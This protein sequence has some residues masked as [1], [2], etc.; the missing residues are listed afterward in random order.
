[1]KSPLAILLYFTLS[2]FSCDV[3]KEVTKEENCA[4]KF[5]IN[6]SSILEGDAARITGRVF[7]LES[8]EVI[9]GATVTLKKEGVLVGSTTDM[10]GKFEIKNVEAGIYELVARSIG[11]NDYTK[12]IEIKN[13]TAYSF[14]IG[15]ESVQAVLLKPVIYVYPTEK[16]EISVK[17]NYQ[18]KLTH[19]YPKYP[20]NGWNVTAEPTGTLWDEKGMEYYALFWE[21]IPSK[22]LEPTEGFIVP[23]HET[24]E[25]LEEK[26]A[27]LGLNRREANEFIMFWLPQM[28][29]NPYNLIHFAGQEYEDQVPLEITPSPETT[30][31]VMM[32]T[33]PLQTKIDFPAQDLTPLKKT[34]KGFTVVEWGGSA[35]DVVEM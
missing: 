30:I 19:T 6:S 33:Q 7:D 3:S 12:V 34:R 13:S 15:L 16:T 29:N 2:F 21:G 8:S 1:M 22:P 9:I 32:L 20:E 4:G 17:L 5:T 23:G 35:V 14:E 11:F 10:D 27:Y 28:E 24:A 26:L 25:F 18:G 31:R